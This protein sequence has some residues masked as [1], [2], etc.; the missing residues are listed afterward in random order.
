MRKILSKLS[1][2][3]SNGPG[4]KALCPS[5]PDFAPSL[6]IDAGEG[7]RVLIHCHAGC[8]T[9]DILTELGLS[10]ADLHTGGGTQ[11]RIAAK[12]PPEEKELAFRSKVYADLLEALP[13]IPAHRSDL[14]ARGL[15]DEQIELRQYRSLTF[16]TA[17]KALARLHEKY[18]E[19]LFT[20]PGFIDDG[21]PRITP[22]SG[23]AIPVRDL[24][25]RV[26][27]V[28]VRVADPIRKYAWMSDRESSAG[29]PTHVPLGFLLSPSSEAAWVTEGPL[30]A[31]VASALTGY[32]FLGT[33]GLNWQSAL[34]ILAQ[35]HAEKVVLAYD[36][37][38]LSKEGV[39]AK[40]DEFAKA[41]RDGGYAVSLAQW[42]NHKG[43]D[44]ALKAREKILVIA[45][46]EAS[47]AK[48]MPNKPP[49]ASP[50]VRTRSG[51]RI[52]TASQIEA[53]PIDWLWKGWLPR[54]G[55]T[56][57]EG[58]PG[59]G[60]SLLFCHIA[61]DVTRG[62]ALP[63]MD[64]RQ[65]PGDVLILS[66]EDDIERTLTPRLIAA[67]ADLSRVHFWEGIDIGTDDLLRLPVFPGDHRD[68]LELIEDLRISLVVLDPLTAYMDPKLDAL[69]DHH[70][71]Q[72]LS[73]LTQILIRTQAAGLGN[74][75]L[76]KMLGTKAIYR[77]LGG[78]GLLG[79]ARSVM[80][81]ERDKLEPQVR[82]LFQVK[83]NLAGEQKPLRL[84]MTERGG[85]ALLDWDGDSEAVLADDDH[86]PSERALRVA[87]IDSWL[88]GQL[89]EGPV[90]AGQILIEAREQK[91]W[92]RRQLDDARERLG[93]R[94]DNK[95]RKSLWW[96]PGEVPRGEA[97]S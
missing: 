15:A 21:R 68:L 59:L 35:A 1:G 95:G 13:L 3:V 34:P 86:V 46:P 80:R 61:A 44:D 56:L 62:R 42:D 47:T 83:T 82:N 76:T 2:V 8:K 72:F 4:F 70:L 75:H 64:R 29:S 43:I 52:R 48:P 50:P 71:R 93:V 28:Q 41:L 97:V 81:L 27:A 88:E 24:S 38:R 6:S 51:L 65:E 33:G 77:G 19:E 54:G 85:V 14:S 57:L 10:W 79:A 5:H 73:V 23:L 84:R 58:D 11:A 22:S 53:K 25:G 20:V 66:A 78:V 36:M 12:T 45:P 31:D 63:R 89:S 17:S 96:P 94:S 40:V 7:G 9:E 60:K 18:G 74:R 69:K 30:K 26:I 90:S 87:E 32:S 55:I 39:A 67:G 49:V 91:G 92:S 16:L 37:D